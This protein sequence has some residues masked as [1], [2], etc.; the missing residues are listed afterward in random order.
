MENILAAT[1]M[2]TPPRRYDRLSKLLHWTT[3]GFIIALFVTIKLRESAQD[4][5]YATMLLTTHRSLGVLLWWVTVVRFAWRFTGAYAPPLPRTV[6]PLQRMASSAMHVAL[7]VLLFVQPL[8][9]L[10]QSLLKGK[11]FALLGGTVPVLVARNRDWQHVFH[12]IHDTG[13]NLFLVLIGLHAVAG[14]LHGVRRDGVLGS[15]AFRAE[16]GD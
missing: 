13:G 4:E 6:G 14:L 5:A 11:A 7:Y 2:A 10:I 12:A 9:G 15:M 1:D 16:R 8:T 3:L